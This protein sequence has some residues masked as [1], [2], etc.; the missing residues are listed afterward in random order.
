VT[1]AG[2][3]SGRIALQVA[4]LVILS[5]LCAMPVFALLEI[6]AEQAPPIDA[7][8]QQGRPLQVVGYAIFVALLSTDPVGRAFYLTVPVLAAAAFGLLQLPWSGWRRVVA[9]AL[10]IGMAYAALFYGGLYVG[11]LGEP[12]FT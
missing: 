1:E 8:S 2:R 4:G 10:G 11:W 3:L 6:F 5:P 7:S 12:F 9:C